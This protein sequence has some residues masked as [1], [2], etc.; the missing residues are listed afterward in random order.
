MKLSVKIPLLLGIVVLASIVAMLVVIEFKVRNAIEKS[1]L[2]S[3]SGEV[4]ANADF[5]KSKLDL[6]LE[7]LAEVATRIR[8][9]SM[10]WSV[11]QPALKADVARLGALD[12]AMINSEGIAHYV[13]GGMTVN[14]KDRAYFNKAMAGEKNVEMVVSRVTGKVVTLFAVPIRETEDMNSP[15]VGVLMARKDGAHTLSNL[16][17]ELKT[18]YESG[19]AFLINEEGI[20]IA[21]RN[22][23][24]VN[25]Q[26]NPVKEAEKDPSLKSLAEMVTLAFEKK[27]GKLEYNYNGKNLIGTHS[28]VPGSNWILFLS[29]EKYEIENKLSQISMVIVWIG[30]ICLIAGIIAAVGVGR[31]IAKPV[32]HVVDAFKDITQGEGDLT[33]SVP[34]H[35]KGE[36]GDLARYFNKLIT[37]IR[38]PIGEAK[39]TVD[40]LITVS[41]ELSLINRQLDT[42]EAANSTKESSQE[43]LRMGQCVHELAAMAGQLR[44]TMDKFK[45]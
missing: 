20:I 41:E 32:I 40:L 33:Q 12:L 25:K 10:D 14:V 9:R 36:M 26:F 3:L 38:I 18:P 27:N 21:H 15:I 17:A 30:F 13:L 1:S 23:E 4:E 6:H 34:V 19:Y 7:V 35:F 42:D 37:T 29:I 16:V 5:L 43:I 44:Q 39:A 22:Q 8:V 45:V 11:V 31:S 24:L 2:D 28:E